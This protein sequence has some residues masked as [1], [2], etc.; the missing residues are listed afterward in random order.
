[1]QELSP[2]SGTP[3]PC[4]PRRALRRK[5]LTG[6]DVIMRRPSK[7]PGGLWVRAVVLGAGRAEAVW[8]GEGAGVGAGAR[9]GRAGRELGE[10]DAPG[11][12]HGGEDRRSRI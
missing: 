3:S 5:I 8:M 12:R 10:G 9:R 1:M 6:V 2:R 4:Y 11:G 7:V